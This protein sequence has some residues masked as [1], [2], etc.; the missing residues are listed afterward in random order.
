M[1]AKHQKNSSLS[2]FPQEMQQ[3]QQQQQQERLLAM[4]KI[5]L[6]EDEYA[7]WPVRE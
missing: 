4:S 5:P 1:K 6:R 3:Q 7:N 2:F